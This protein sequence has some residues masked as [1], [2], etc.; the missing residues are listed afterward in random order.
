[1][2]QVVIVDDEPIIRFGLKSSIKWEEEGLHLIGDFSNGKQALDAIQK[3][4]Q[5]DI[6]ITDI[7]MPVMDGIHLMK[8]ALALFPKL[9]VILVSSYNDFEYIRE[10]LQ[11]GAID[12]VLKASLEP[13]AFLQIIKK[14]TKKLKKEKEEE[15]ALRIANQTNLLLEKKKMA[16]EVRKVLLGETEVKKLTQFF[17]DD[18]SFITIYIKMK[19][20]QKV[21]EEKGIL[22]KSLLLEEIQALYYE[23]HGKGIL[24]PISDVEMFYLCPIEKDPIEV[25]H[26]LQ[27]LITKITTISFYYGYRTIEHLYD[28]P[29]GY[30]RSYIA[31][32]KHFFEPNQLQFCY[33]DEIDGKIK[34]ESVNYHAC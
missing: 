29:I 24:F 2:H 10:G 20:I 28:L 23:E 7:K 25:I 30:Q 14:C 21:E 33:D 16:Q 18:S 3:H 31:C 34:T 17:P 13:D 6:L 1:M 32:S 9:K 26:Y 19:D 5:V 12:Y 22:Y 11:Y 15:E 4:H 27:K 8:Q